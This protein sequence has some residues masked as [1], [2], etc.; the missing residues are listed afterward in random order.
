MDTLLFVQDEHRT[1]SSNTSNFM[2]PSKL[3]QTFSCT[4]Y[5]HLHSFEL[6][7]Q[8]LQKP[9]AYF[10][11]HAAGGKHVFVPLQLHHDGM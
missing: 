9:K 2:S 8:Q 5:S 6:S 11:T 7:K 3:F 4:T 10:I 1:V